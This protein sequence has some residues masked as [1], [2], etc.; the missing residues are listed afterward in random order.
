MS[1]SS[2]FVIFGILNLQTRVAHGYDLLC[3]SSFSYKRVRGRNIS[4]T[5]FTY[6]FSSTSS[7]SQTQIS[8]FAD[9]EVQKAEKA[10]APPFSFLAQRLL[11][12]GK[13]RRFKGKTIPIPIVL[14]HSLP[15]LHQLLN[16]MR[17]AF[18]NNAEF[19]SFK[20]PSMITRPVAKKLKKR[21]CFSS[22]V[23]IAIPSPHYTINSLR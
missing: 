22:D 15:S 14:E 16:K 21:Y 1:L 9:S 11:S 19:D 4:F 12:R 13:I 2:I 5:P 7:S 23:K 20:Y 6:K 3:K 8:L 17:D 10:K 18:P